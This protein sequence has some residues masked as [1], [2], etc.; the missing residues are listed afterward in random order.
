MQIFSKRFVS[1]LT[2][3]LILVNMILFSVICTS[4]LIMNSI[5]EYSDE[6]V[7]GNVVYHK[8]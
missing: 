7:M 6:K 1:C 8:L 3:V 4:R 2:Q 5:T